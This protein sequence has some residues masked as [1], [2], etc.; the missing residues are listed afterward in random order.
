[1][2]HRKWIANQNC[3]R[4]LFSTNTD[5]KSDLLLWK[6][7]IFW[8]RQWKGLVIQLKIREE[9]LFYDLYFIKLVNTN[10]SLRENRKKCLSVCNFYLFLMTHSTYFYGLKLKSVL[11]T[12]YSFHD[13][14]A[15]IFF[16][17]LK[18]SEMNVNMHHYKFK[19]AK[20]TEM[21]R[22]TYLNQNPWSFWRWIGDIKHEVRDVSE[23]QQ[24]LI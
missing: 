2:S 24:I 5:M 6:W 23:T 8:H 13:H 17:F 10:L 18:T 22:T 20:W 15:I 16:G 1:M 3:I 4:V 7:W 19:N 12:K 9:K 11:N 14:P 21:Y